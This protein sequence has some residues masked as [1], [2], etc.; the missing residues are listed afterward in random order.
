MYDP[1]GECDVEETKEVE[2]EKQA[3]KSNKDNF[4]FSRKMS[5][6][7]GLNHEL[8]EIVYVPEKIVR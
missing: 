1:K 5:G 3:L 7:M 6:G 4:I 2:Q 8:E